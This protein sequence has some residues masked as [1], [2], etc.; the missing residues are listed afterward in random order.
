[1]DSI[2]IPGR[3]VVVHEQEDD[4]SPGGNG[5]GRIACRVIGIE[6]NDF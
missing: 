6:K 4:L 5:G 3:E 1:V 2:L